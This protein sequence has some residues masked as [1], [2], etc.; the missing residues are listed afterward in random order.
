MGVRT[1][2]RSGSTGVSNTCACRHARNSGHPVHTGA[3][4]VHTSSRKNFPKPPRNTAPLNRGDRLQAECQRVN[5]HLRQQLRLHLSR[6]SPR[7]L[8]ILS[9]SGGNASVHGRR[10][11]ISPESPATCPNPRLA[12]RG[13]RAITGMEGDSVTWMSPATRAGTP[14]RPDSRRR[15]ANKTSKMQVRTQFF[16]EI[17]QNFSP[18]T[19]SPPCFAFRSHRR[20]NRMPRSEAAAKGN[21]PGNHVVRRMPALIRLRIAGRGLRSPAIRKQPGPATPPSKGA[22]RRIPGKPPQSSGPRMTIP[23][24]CGKCE[25]VQIP[26]RWAE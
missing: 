6:A 13:A 7:V 17:H 11:I 15:S 8:V 19:L 18:E 26:P 10:E 20:P 24:V 3:P 2:D 25:H 22:P 1:G 12:R 4:V 16:P 5:R 23:P 9:H 21:I 14:P